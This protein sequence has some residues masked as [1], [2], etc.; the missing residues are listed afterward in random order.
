M[1]GDMAQ[2]FGGKEYHLVVGSDGL[3]GG[4]FMEVTEGRGGPEVMDVF[5]S[6]TTSEMTVSAYRR[7]LPLEL[8]E[9]A[10]V[11]ARARLTPISRD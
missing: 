10:V 7:D 4:M 2:A 8:V 11:Q 5:Y 9:W 1:I 6:D 3:R